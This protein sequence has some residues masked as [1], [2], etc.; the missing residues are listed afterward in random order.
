MKVKE[1]IKLLEGFDP[2][3]EVILQKD[4]EGNGYSPLYGADPYAVYVED[5]IWSGEVYDTRWT[6]EDAGME[7]AEWKKLLKKKHCVVLHPM[8]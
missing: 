2:K 4:S 5:S 6:A 8:N 3:A 7:E 1:L